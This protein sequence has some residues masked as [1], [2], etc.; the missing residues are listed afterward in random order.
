MTKSYLVSF[1]FISFFVFGLLNA[2]QQPGEVIGMYDV[3]SITFEFFGEQ[4]YKDKKLLKLLSF[5]KDDKID[6]V[7]L[8]FGRED[9]EDFYRK[10]GFAFVEIS[11]EQSDLPDNKVVYTINEGPRVKIKEVSFEGNKAFK[12]STLKGQIKTGKKKWFFWPD[13]FDV[14]Q[15]L[16]DQ[17]NLQKFYVKRGF[18]DCVVDAKRDFSEDK[19][20]A[21]ITFELDEG[22]IY[23]IKDIFINGAD[24]IYD[25]VKELNETQLRARLKLREGETYLEHIAESD[26]KGL[27]ELY[28][29]YG[30]LNAKIRLE[31]HRIFQEIE[32]RDEPQGVKERKVTVVF[33]VEEDVPFRIG[34]IDITGNM[35]TK[36]RVIRRV[37]DEYDFTPGWLYNADIAR[38]DGTGELEKKVQRMASVEEAAIT[39]LQEYEPGQKNVEVRVKEGKTGS[40]MLGGGIGS[41]TGFV[42]QL[43]F[44]QRN[45]DVTDWPTGWGDFFSGEAFKGGGQRLRISLQPGLKYS[46]YLISFSEPYL[47]DKPLSLDVKASSFER[48]MEGFDENFD[49]TITRGY[50]GIEKRYKG[51]NRRSVSFRLFNV[52]IDADPEAPRQ[53][54]EVQGD[55]LLGGIKFALGRNTTDERFSPSKGY[56]T[57]AGYEQLT[58]E[59]TFGK[60]SASFKWYKT[61][62]EDLAERKTVLGTKLL[63]GTTIGDAPPF[64]KYYAGGIGTYSLRGFKYRGI[65]PRGTDS[66]DPVGSDWIFLADSEVV[67]PIV[68]ES[69]FGVVF[70]DSGTVETGRYR[71]SVG[72]GIQLLIPQWFGPVPMRFQLASPVLKDDSDKEEVFSFC[73]GRLF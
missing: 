38:G 60:L 17:Q 66:D 39:P 48:D 44:E 12:K 37:L 33:A 4:N 69:L 20:R 6:I 63:A 56:D 73:V 72:A 54:K 58:G 35:D 64:E 2:Q 8:D 40:V 25:V 65:S 29:K 53:I 9:L 34:R 28:H 19:T 45:F 1:I 43:M 67:S 30:F 23:Q 49:Q 22:P 11:F 15:L 16:E 51:G 70:L 3:E 5:S 18:L 42:G 27:L 36:D 57:S 13:Y 59:D 55:N 26:R 32:S 41:D 21:Y 62:Y 52:D 68:G 46:E 24:K 71:A 31:I 47:N 61:I 7:E 14:E 10:K 50:V